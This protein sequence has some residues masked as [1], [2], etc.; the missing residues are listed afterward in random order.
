MLFKRKKN[1]V[2]PSALPT[3]EKQILNE[4]VESQ[5]ENEEQEGDFDSMD[6]KRIIY[7][8]LLKIPR[9]EVLVDWDWN[10]TNQTHKHYFFSGKGH[11]DQA[12]IEFISN[13]LRLDVGVNIPKQESN[14]DADYSRANKS[15]FCYEKITND[16]RRKYY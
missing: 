2:I 11:S 3:E 16:G 8:P 9:L 5:S 15:K 14:D 10:P 12:P 7:D 13:S 6:A 1:K 4:G